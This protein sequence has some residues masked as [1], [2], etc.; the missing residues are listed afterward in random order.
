[1]GLKLLFCITSLG[2]ALGQSNVG[3]L[4]LPVHVISNSLQ[5]TVHKRT[6]V[7]RVLTLLLCVQNV[8]VGEILPL[9]L[10]H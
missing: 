1:M 5:D 7:L 8:L 10:R 4:L 9:V 3:V 2:D 6:Q